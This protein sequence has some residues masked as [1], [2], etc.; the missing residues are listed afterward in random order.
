MEE[1]KRRSKTKTRIEKG[2]WVKEDTTKIIN[3]GEKK[4]DKGKRK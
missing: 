3:R 1:G 2:D 4:E